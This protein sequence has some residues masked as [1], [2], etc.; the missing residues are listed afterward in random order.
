M[1]NL[2]K[3]K[4]KADL[5]AKTFS[6]VYHA[7][8]DGL[9]P[10]TEQTVASSVESIWLAE[11]ELTPRFL[12]SSTEVRNVVR[13][14][15]LTGATELDLIDNK[16]LRHLP[17]KAIVCLTHLFNA[18]LKFSYFPIAWK[19]A[20]VIPILKPSKDPTASKSYRPISLLSTVGKLFERWILRCLK[21][22]INSSGIYRNEQ[23]E[24]REGHSATHQLL[25]VV[26]HIKSGLQAKLSTG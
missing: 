21:C 18:C 19:R 3:N 2:K 25:R 6:D 23:F 16:L 15:R 24:F 8:D 1:H 17:R 5:V 7:H 13:V 14:L 10:V 26:K 9:N 22:H 11:V 12:I 20:N 4:D